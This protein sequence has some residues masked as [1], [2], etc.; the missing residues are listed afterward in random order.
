M[1]GEKK[2]KEKDESGVVTSLVLCKQKL[3][4]AALIVL[5]VGAAAGAQDA[6]KPFP[7]ATIRVNVN[8]VNVAVSVSDS[9]GQFVQKLTQKDFRVFDNGIE[10]AITGFLSADEPGQVVLMVE[11]GTAAFYLGKDELKTSADL[12][13]RIPPTERIAVVSYTNHARLMLDFTNEKM[14]A[15]E[16]LQRLTGKSAIGG[17]EAD[18]A[19]S[20]GETLDWLA[21][22]PGKKIIVLLSSG[23]ATSS[24]AEWSG[25]ER[26]LQASDVRVIG[27]SISGDLG[28]MPKWRKLSPQEKEDRAYIRK[29][30]AEADQSIR[31][32]CLATGGRT[33]FPKS[34]KEFARVYSEIAELIRHEYNLAFTPAELDGRIHTIAVKLKRGG[35]RVEHRQGYLASATM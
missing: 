17:K 5:S 35:L 26:K 20:L 3:F 30:L 32:I 18:L 10:Q 11:G 23:V 6:Q 7:E 16:T 22:I 21:G 27:I 34:A 28:R 25:I 33:Y 14:A 2:V 1:A 9:H 15:R 4:L 19:E 8:R 29:V 13:D 12:L 31:G 24:P